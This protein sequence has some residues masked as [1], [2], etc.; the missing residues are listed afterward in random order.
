MVKAMNRV[1]RCRVCEFEYFERDGRP[2]EGIPPGTAWD[3]IPDHWTC[4]DCGM[5]KADFVM[6]QQ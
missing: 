6:V 5:S 4:P 1:W 2:E 3:D